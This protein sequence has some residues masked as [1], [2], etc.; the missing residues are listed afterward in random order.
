MGIVRIIEKYELKIS[1]KYKNII[2]NSVQTNYF[3]N[4]LRNE[5]IRDL[6]GVLRK[7]EHFLS[8]YFGEY[9]DEKLWEEWEAI[10]IEMRL[11]FQNDNVGGWSSVYC[12][13][14]WNA[15][16]LENDADWNVFNILFKIDTENQANLSKIF[17]YLCH[18]GAF[19]IIKVNI[20]SK[21]S[22]IR[23]SVF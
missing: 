10:L 19:E 7:F 18:D 14:T 8:F 5:A 2:Q 12:T 11:Y 9:Y 23:I 15:S 13:E 22:C 17:S 3:F 21:H 6:K 1:S 16:T 20:I 4:L